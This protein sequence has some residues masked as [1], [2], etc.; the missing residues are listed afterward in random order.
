MIYM[1]V[2][3]YL[4]LLVLVQN[5]KKINNCRRSDWGA[6][7]EDKIGGL[8][9]SLPFLLPQVWMKTILMIIARSI[10]GWSFFIPP[11]SEDSDEVRWTSLA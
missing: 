2:Q 9:A 6:W 3:N 4:M 5:Q 10:K 7:C 1:P 8:F 11:E